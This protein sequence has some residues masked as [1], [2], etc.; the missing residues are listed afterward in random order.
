M[1][2]I[3]IHAYISGRVQGVWYRQSAKEKAESLA[4]AGWVRNL[5]DGRVELIAAGEQ[6]AVRQLEAWLSQG[7]ELANVIDVSSSI[8]EKPDIPQ[9]FEVR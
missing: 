7:P 2:E 9:L 6:L 1:A 4:I 8:I 5:E 3:C